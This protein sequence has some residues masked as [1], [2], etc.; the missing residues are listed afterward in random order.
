MTLDLS[1]NVLIVDDSGFMRKMFIKNLQDIGYENIIEAVDGEDA[2]KKI[3]ANK[4]D[5][6]ICDWNMPNRDGKSLVQWIR[7]NAQYKAIPF[8]MAT[9]QGDKSKE[10]EAKE[11]GANNHIAKPFTAE[12]L[13]EKIEEVFGLRAKEKASRKNIPHVK[14]KVKL[15]VAHIQITDH[16][17]LGVL[18]HHIQ[19]GQITPKYFE[20]ETIKMDSWNPVQKA[21]ETGEVDGAFVLAPIAMDLFA[22]DVP[23]KLVM[24]AHKNGSIMVRS[25]SKELLQDGAVE[26]IYFNRVVCIPHKMSVHNMLAH[27]FLKELGLT[28]GVPGQDDINVRF[29]VI[30]PIKMPITMLQNKEIAGFIVAEPIGTTAITKGIAEKQFTSGSFWKNHPCCVN[31]FRDEAIANYTDAIY[32]FTALL[33]QAGKF[34]EANKDIAAEIAVDF[35]DPERKLGF[36]KPIIQRI[37][38]EPLGIKMDDLYPVIEDL[39]TIQRYMFGEMGIGTIIDLEKFIDF[40]FANVTAKNWF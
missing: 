30:P 26:D 12:E 10:E 17:A 31:V 20:L 14:G 8:I 16:L 40:R 6:I 11:A 1:I 37:L 23:I 34:I 9:A 7:S 2:I 29:E 21:L 22:F 13:K 36:N 24:L 32:E 27:M 25:K 39:D 5:L 4:V 33:S 28:P 18:K 38:E 3:E 19:T 35:L 15:K